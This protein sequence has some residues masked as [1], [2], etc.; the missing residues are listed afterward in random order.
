MAVAIAPIAIA[1][2]AILIAA[3]FDRNTEPARVIT[4]AP[5]C[6]RRHAHAI[7]HA[8]VGGDQRLR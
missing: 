8:R 2:A 7:T 3:S 6:T 4:G 5:S 1:L